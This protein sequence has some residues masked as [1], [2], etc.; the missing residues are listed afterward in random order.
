MKTT[1]VADVYYETSLGDNITDKK[2]HS[3]KK[4]ENRSPSRSSDKDHRRKIW[5]EAKKESAFLRVSS[6]SSSYNTTFEERLYE[7]GLACR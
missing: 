2:G 4:M 5:N 7:M 3:L 6:L 1:M